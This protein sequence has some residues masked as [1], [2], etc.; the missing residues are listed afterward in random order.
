MRQEP[1]L[2]LTIVHAPRPLHYTAL[3]SFSVGT[4]VVVSMYDGSRYEVE[5]K[6]T[7]FINMHSRGAWPRVD[8]A[9]LSQVRMPFVLVEC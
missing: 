7:Q 5:C 1:N 8:M 2:G 9:P 3:F 6:Y 4:D